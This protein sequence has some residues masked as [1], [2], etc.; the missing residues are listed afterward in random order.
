MTPVSVSISSGSAPPR[1]RDR[2]DDRLVEIVEQLHARGRGELES[3]A[4]SFISML[5]TSCSIVS[6][7]SLG[8]ASM[9]ISR[10]L[11]EHAAVLDA[12]GLVGAVQ[13]EGPSPGS[14]P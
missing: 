1:R 4:V 6:G 11:L 7:I 5:E 2:R 8:S 3:V 12:G 13:V 10:V 14:R 9:L